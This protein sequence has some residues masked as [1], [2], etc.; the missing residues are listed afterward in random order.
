LLP[1]DDLEVLAIECDGVAM[2]D[3]ALACLSFPS[4]FV[5]GA[6]VKLLKE[7]IRYSCFTDEIRSVYV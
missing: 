7:L 6:S 1:Q 5:V 2:L 3:V 4:H